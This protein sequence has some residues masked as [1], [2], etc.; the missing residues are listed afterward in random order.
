MLLNELQN[1][2]RQIEQQ[3]ETM[4]LLAA[5]LAALERLLPTKALPP[6]PADQ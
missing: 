6:T 1:E 2:H 4:G 5:R 3:A